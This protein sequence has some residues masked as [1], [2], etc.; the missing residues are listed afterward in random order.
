MSPE[1]NKILASAL[2][3]SSNAMLWMLPEKILFKN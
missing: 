1:K 3:N 2:Q